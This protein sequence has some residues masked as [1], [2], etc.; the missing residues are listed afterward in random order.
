MLFSSIACRAAATYSARMTALR[1]PAALLLAALTFTIC[2]PRALAVDYPY[3]TGKEFW[4]L[5]GDGAL[6]TLSWP[7]SQALQIKVQ[8]KGSEVVRFPM[9]K[10]VAAQPD[11]PAK[12]AFR[13]DA[14][15]K[16]VKRAVNEN[17]SSGTLSFPIHRSVYFDQ[18]RRAARVL[19]IIT[20]TDSKDHEVTLHYITTWKPE[21]LPKL[22]SMGTYLPAGVN[23]RQS[24]GHYV[25]FTEP[26]PHPSP[27][28]ILGIPPK[29][30]ARLDVSSREAFQWSYTGQL[31]TGKQIVLLHWL[32]MKDGD[33][34][35]DAL[36]IGATLI[37]D[38]MPVDDT[39]SPEILAD[40]A[41]FKPNQSLFPPRPTG[42]PQEGVH[43]YFLKA[44]RKK[45]NLT[46][47]LDHDYLALRNG[48]LLK[49]ELHLTGA[50]VKAADMER[51]LQLPMVAA[52]Q[53]GS[54]AGGKATVHYRSGYT[55]TG[56]VSWQDATFTDA[57][58][59]TFKITPD[60]MDVLFLRSDKA[61]HLPM[62]FALLALSIEG[63][64]RTLQELPKDPVRMHWACGEL[65][66]S[67]G[68]LFALQQTPP[69]ALGY[70]AFLTDGSRVQV[71][72]AGQPVTGL[73][74]SIAACTRTWPDLIALREGN[75]VKP[76]TKG[77]SL[78]TK[79]GSLI[80]GTWAK[81]VLLLSCAGT[82]LKVSTAEIR[83][84]TRM[85]EN[86]NPAEMLEILTA[87]NVT[88]KGFPVDGTLSWKWQDRTYNLPWSQ[89]VQ[90]ASD[91]E[92]P[93][94]AAPAPTSAKP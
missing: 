54:A 4:A 89:I 29:N 93:A 61:Q 78:E 86:E 40:L 21:I 77:P 50:H 39:L 69:P 88:L 10:P 65:T 83:R 1:W 33:T 37:K 79:D 2:S 66:V 57:S 60:S 92:A 74:R 45:Y 91:A 80:A 9:T 67:W 42:P 27:F 72:L 20:N 90:I 70:E 6:I 30:W 24:F 56:I 84:L 63:D 51:D 55:A 7:L 52:I 34:Y 11:S 8:V 19:D 15:M 5:D 12:P 87:A 3:S 26:A 35:E 44:L 76:I 58:I 41:N 64:I 14:E 28:F 22:K 62:P 17:R 59:G 81:D 53:G 49:G 16:W 75:F 46:P 32:A 85:T 36:K 25:N 18:A 94:N 31:A 43:N 71:W 68:S 23:S 13:S 47:D 38:G 82:E 73:P 48:P